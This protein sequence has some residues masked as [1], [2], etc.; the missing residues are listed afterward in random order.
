MARSEPSR[1]R[2]KPRRGGK[3]GR[4]GTELIEFTGKSATG[5]YEH[6]TL[7]V[8]SNRGITVVGAGEV[9]YDVLK[10][11]MSASPIVVAADG[12]AITA[13]RFGITPKVVIGD[14]DS[15]PDRL[16]PELPAHSL[17]HITDQNTTDFEKCLRSLDTPLVVAVGVTNPRIDHGL[18][19]INAL[20]RHQG[21]RIVL[22]NSSDLC[23][24]C[25]PVFEI[26]LPL[27]TQFSLFPMA[28]TSGRS[29]GL[30]WPIDGIRFSPHGTIGTSNFTVAK[31]VRVRI[32]EPGMIAILPSNH[33][34]VAVAALRR[35]SS[36]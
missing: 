24:L 10:L 30:N 33:F 22:L 18:S 8:H 34:H 5:D 7:P 12:G 35:A 26:L 14:M 6:G 1:S 9:S 15:L 20:A 4:E 29:D 13:L 11:A 36:W 31:I 21:K 3:L 32:D 17:V 2:L 28:E 25:P 16:P 23:F 27:H 19:A